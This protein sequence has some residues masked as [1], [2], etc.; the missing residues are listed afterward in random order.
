MIEIDDK[1]LNFSK[2]NINT[3]KAPKKGQSIFAPEVEPNKLKEKA[4]MLEE[5]LA[6]YADI[7]EN[8]NSMVMGLSERC[9]KHRELR[10][11]TLKRTYKIDKI[12]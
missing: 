3:A 4:V 1:V 9:K 5:S 8:R 6:R 2:Q 12:S 7:Y 10:L 11:R